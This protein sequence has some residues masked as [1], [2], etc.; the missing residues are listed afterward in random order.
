MLTY[1]KC[2]ICLSQSVELD[3][4]PQKVFPITLQTAHLKGAFLFDFNLVSNFSIYH[5]WVFL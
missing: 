2:N 4:K 5:S 1:F 3:K